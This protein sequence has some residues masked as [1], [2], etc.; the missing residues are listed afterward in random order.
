MAVS[1][2]QI[3]EL[4]EVTGVSMMACKKALT[5]T[6]G[7]ID[8]AIDYLRKKGESKAMERSERGTGQGV[9]ASYIHSN[10]KLGVLL[11]LGCE[12]DFVAKN[13][14]FIQTAQDIAMHIAAMN[15]LTVSPEEVTDEI[16]NKEKE[17]W[18]EQLKAEGKNESII[19]NILIGKE[20][21]FREEGALLTQAFVKNPEI[22]IDQ[23]VK[24]LINKMGE[25]I[26]VVKFCR[27]VI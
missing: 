2:D 16:V 26:K 23:L 22:S 3:K 27:Y 4:R 5:E 9:I 20:K 13:A 1:L 10:A 14:D 21:K 19:A 17:I 7:D 8:K 15:P 24:D 6:N 25:N 18:V 12:T 11:H